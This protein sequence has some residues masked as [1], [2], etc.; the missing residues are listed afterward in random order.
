MIQIDKDD[1]YIILDRTPKSYYSN[2]W[3]LSLDQNKEMI[4]D[5]SLIKIRV[6]KNHIQLIFCMERSKKHYKF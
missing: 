3:S 6:K 1:K 5:I 4:E 2:L